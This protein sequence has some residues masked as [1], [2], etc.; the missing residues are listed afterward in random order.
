MLAVG[1]SRS[2]G[3]AYRRAVVRQLAVLG[4]AGAEAAVGGHFKAI[5]ALE[6]KAVEAQGLPRDGW[7]IDVGCGAGRLAA[8]LRD[9]PKL[10]YL[11]IDV[12]PPLIAHARAATQRDDWRFELVDRPAIPAPD[13]VA[14]VV[15]MFS[16]IT[17][18]AEPD[19]RAYFA[20]IARV[21]KPQG[22]AVVSF[23]DPVIP[24]HRAQIRPAW[25]EAIVTR[26][27]WAPNV[28]TPAETLR[29]WATAAG[30]DVARIESPAP[31]GQS[32]I[33][34][35]PQSARTTAP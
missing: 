7:L 24:A 35:Q 31:I 15:A 34:L 12:S 19:T 16:V 30:L 1:Q 3:G 20:E 33:V 9:W 18:L 27:A 26:I 28:A 5:G 14:D 13:Q 32:I 17:H 23:L 10:R 22:S 21:L 25:L 11:G 4:P 29:G 2:Y 6:K 8:T